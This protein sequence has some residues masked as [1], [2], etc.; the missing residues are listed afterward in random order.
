MAAIQ[1]RRKRKRIALHWPV[2]LFRDQ[3]A[4]SVESTT[5]NLTSNGF[6]C[7]SKELFQ[8]GEQ[9]KCVIS[10]PAGA[11]GYSEAPVRLQCRVKV[12]RVE[13]QSENFGLGCYIE[14]YELLINSKPESRRALTADP[15]R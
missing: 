7:V 2:Y 14:D 6:Y 8:P 11:F 9:L 10:I 4:Q 13:D 5:E 15:G 1:E 12:M 3:S